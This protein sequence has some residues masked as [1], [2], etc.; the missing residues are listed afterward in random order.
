MSVSTLLY[1]IYLS[2]APCRDTDLIQGVYS[3]HGLENSLRGT[4]ELARPVSCSG[5]LHTGVS[6][7]NGAGRSGCARCPPHEAASCVAHVELDYRYI[8]SAFQ[9]HQIFSN[10]NPYLQHLTA[11]AA[12]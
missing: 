12:A 3:W 2:A 6:V 7:W 11:R 5:Q 4:L 10:K 8:L 1:L 9:K